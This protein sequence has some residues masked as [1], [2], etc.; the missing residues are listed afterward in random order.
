MK[1]TS[2]FKSIIAM[3]VAFAAGSANAQEVVNGLSTLDAKACAEI[4]VKN[5][6]DTLV[7]VSSINVRNRTTGSVSAVKV[8]RKAYLKGAEVAFQTLLSGEGVTEAMVASLS[9][10]EIPFDN[11]S[12]VKGQT[13]APQVVAVAPESDEVEVSHGQD[14]YISNLSDAQLADVTANPDRYYEPTLTDAAGKKLNW[15]TVGLYGGAK[16][17]QGGDVTPL[18]GVNAELERNRLIL[19]LW[20][21]MS[22][23]EH[24]GTAEATGRYTELSLGARMGWKVFQSADR[25]WYI[26]PMIGAGYQSQK[27]DRDDAQI[28]SKNNGFIWNAD[29]RFSKV[30]WKNINLFAELGVG[31]SVSVNHGE[32]QEQNLTKL[33]GHAKVGVSASF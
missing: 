12:V 9:K 18:V 4:L 20:G 13:V 33:S 6:A 26:A 21:E 23:K 14:G 7:G 24:T 32:E 3:M 15:W 31:S 25:N 17:T 27:T 16:W 30:I 2:F 5:P 29:V 28:S 1:A 19:G 11:V 22:S 8:T 10:K